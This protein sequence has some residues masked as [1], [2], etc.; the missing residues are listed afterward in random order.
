MIPHVNASNNDKE[1]EEIDLSNLYQYE[2]QKRTYTF[3]V[4]CGREKA[5]YKE[6]NS[7][8]I[9]LF[10]FSILT[11][12]PTSYNISDLNWYDQILLNRPLRVII[13]G[14]G[15]AVLA[16]LLIY[17]FVF[18]S[19]MELPPSDGFSVGSCVVPRADRLPCGLGDIPQA[20][21]HP[22]CCY[23]L[24]SNMCFHRYPSRFSYIMDRTWS[25]EVMLQPRI[26]T[27]PFS[28]QSSIPNIRIS[29]DEI[30]ES[31]M[32]LQFYDARQMSLTGR[33][34]EEKHYSYQVTSP[35][36]SVSVEAAQGLIFNTIRGPLIA[37]TDIWEIAFKLTNETMYGLGDIP[38]RGD[39]SKVIYSHIG[40][41]SSIPLIFAKV[42]GS[43]HGLLIDA[44]APT[45]VLVFEEN[46]ILVRSITSSGLKLH[47]FAG[48]RPSDVMEDVRKLI[49]VN[50]PLEY[51]MLGAHICRYVKKYYLVHK[52]SKANKINLSNSK[53]NLGQA[54][55]VTKLSLSFK[56]QPI[57]ST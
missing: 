26:A 16:P 12:I 34:I 56:H 57:L 15:A 20:E 22:Q 30:S 18:F 13:V 50:D 19:S 7:D 1:T 47:V 2:K 31:H 49:G 33:R 21:C 41:I 43:Y 53:S 3:P 52:N 48:P 23:D 40:G 37:S 51:W 28:H 4:N 36:M 5:Y 39:T 35:E 8:R 17:H 54:I 14:L 25:E 45:E 29:I 9:S 32:S 55:P 38:L 27:V 46:Q 44:V 24:N 10:Y 6:W 11:F 42:N